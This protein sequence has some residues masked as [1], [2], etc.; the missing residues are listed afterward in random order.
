M[1]YRYL[2]TRGAERGLAWTPDP[3][4]G[5]GAGSREPRPRNLAVWI[6]VE[7]ETVTL[8]TVDPGDIAL[9]DKLTFVLT[10]NIRLV[11]ASPAEISEFIGRNYGEAG[12]ESVDS[13][14]QEFNDSESEPDTIDTDDA[15]EVFAVASRAPVAT[16]GASRRGGLAPARSLRNPAPAEPRPPVP[17]IRGLDTIR[18]LGGSGVFTYV[19][20][21]CQH[22]LMR[23][24]DGTMEVLAGPKRVWRGRNTFHPMPHYVAHPGEYL[25]ARYRDGRQEHRPGLGW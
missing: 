14:L 12:G 3:G 17:A 7:G 18:P 25:V 24:P 13:M 22:A 9:A 6:S 19:V 5:S 10:R 16:H 15:S 21:K 4:G 8:A 2:Q 23:R 11:P 1:Q 20:D